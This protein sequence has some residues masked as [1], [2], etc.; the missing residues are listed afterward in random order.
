M[1]GESYTLLQYNYE[2]RLPQNRGHSENSILHWF[3]EDFIH[4]KDWPFWGESPVTGRFPSPRVVYI[5]R[6]DG[7]ME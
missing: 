5:D 3:I 1:T 2:N 6:L 7:W 4:D